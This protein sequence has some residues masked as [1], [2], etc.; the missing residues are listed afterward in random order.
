MFSDRPKTI[1][2][3]SFCEMDLTDNFSAPLHR[4]VINTYTVGVWFCA[5]AVIRLTRLSID[6]IFD[7]KAYKTFN[8][9]T[10]Y[11][12][13]TIQV[14]RDHLIH[15]K[16]DT[17][18]TTEAFFKRIYQNFLFTKGKHMT[19]D[20]KKHSAMRENGALYQ[21]FFFVIDLVNIRKNGR[22]ARKVAFS[23][24]TTIFAKCETLKSATF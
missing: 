11:A 14:S 9:D 17:N 2:A 13:L 23:E 7:M 6:L 24:I 3:W 21:E 8:C 10:G 16:K 5:R 20:I 12:R 19:Y 18:I 4:Y 1:D 22:I 15:L